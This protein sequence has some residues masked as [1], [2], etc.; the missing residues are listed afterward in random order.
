MVGSP[1]GNV[2]LSLGDAGQGGDKLDD[3]WFTR[4]WR[5]DYLDDTESFEELEVCRYVA[6]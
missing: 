5:R 3:V 1:V 6:R 2:L 4:I